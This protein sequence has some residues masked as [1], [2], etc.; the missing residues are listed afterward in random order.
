ML[1]KYL[2]NFEGCTKNLKKFLEKL[3]GILSKIN[4]RF[5]YLV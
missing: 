5:G 1:K 2:G 4:M 3:E